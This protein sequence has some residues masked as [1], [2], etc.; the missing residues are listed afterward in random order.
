MVLVTAVLVLDSQSEIILFMHTA[1]LPADSTSNWETVETVLEIFS[2]QHPL[3]RGVN[4]TRRRYSFRNSES[5]PLPNLQLIFLDLCHPR[6]SVAN[7]CSR[8]ALM[9]GGDCIRDART[10]HPAVVAA[11]SHSSN[12][13]AKRDSASW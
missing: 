12:S 9:A 1:A 7:F 4:E 6:K 8:Y 5:R 11:R 13:S 10:I 2:P 3:K